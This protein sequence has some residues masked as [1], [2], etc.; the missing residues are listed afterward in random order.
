MRHRADKNQKE[1]VDKLRDAGVSVLILSQVGKGC[2]DLLLGYNRKNY[3]VEIKTEV[4]KLKAEQKAFMNKW[5]GRPVVVA[6]S[7][8]E[9]YAIIGLSGF[10]S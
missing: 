10:L 4:G 8:N 9:I 1:I 7:I 3:L 5:H 2:P 6:R